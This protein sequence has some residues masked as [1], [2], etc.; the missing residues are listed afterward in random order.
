MRGFDRAE[1]VEGVA[2]GDEEDEDEA[3][4][5]DEVEEDAC[6][7]RIRQRGNSMGV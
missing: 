3:D 1:A 2:K 5:V 6:Q 4:D 7:Q